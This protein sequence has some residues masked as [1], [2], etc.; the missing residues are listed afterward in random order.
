M[1]HII[2]SEGMKVDPKKIEAMQTKPAPKKSSSSNV[3]LGSLDTIINLLR[4]AVL[5][6]KPLNPSLKKGLD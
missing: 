6:Q 2:T 1:G 4:M 5:S 3:F